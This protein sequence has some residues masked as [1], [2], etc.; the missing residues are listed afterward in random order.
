MT[1][2]KCEGSKQAVVLWQTGQGEKRFLSRNP[3][4]SW[5]CSPG[6]PEGCGVAGSWIV[7]SEPIG[8]NGCGAWG[9]WNGSYEYEYS[10][11]SRRVT[12]VSLE[13]FT[14]DNPFIFQG[15]IKS[16]C[17]GRTMAESL[18]K[19][20]SNL[21]VIHAKMG[22]KSTKVSGNSRDDLSIEVVQSES[23][24]F[25]YIYSN[26]KKRN[27][28]QAIRSSRNSFDLIRKAVFTADS[29]QLLEK[30]YFKIWDARGQVYE[31]RVETEC[32]TVKVICDKACPSSTC[33][34][35]HGNRVCCYNS[36][37]YVIHSFLI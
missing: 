25:S 16:S 7:D 20:P 4:I 26:C 6:P 24:Y 35:R 33:E 36:Q 2:K 14:S 3:P 11:S 12:T 23:L 17:D 31:E 28:G 8:V 18:R 22:A 29:S 34:C 32:P 15:T 10:S 13:G 19:K 5:V 21:Q 9:Y 1:E 27:L 37:G 30:G